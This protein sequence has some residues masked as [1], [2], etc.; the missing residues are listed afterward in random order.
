MSDAAA[1]IN[2]VAFNDEHQDYNHADET[3]D[4]DREVVEEESLPADMTKNGTNAS[5]GGA[6]LTD[7]VHFANDEAPVQAN[8]NEQ[9]SEV[10]IEKHD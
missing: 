5:F 8:N 7:S 9:T 4:K 6:Q 2:P 3:E 1:E 10:S